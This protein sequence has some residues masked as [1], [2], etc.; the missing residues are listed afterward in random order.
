MPKRYDRHTAAQLE[1]NGGN[2]GQ[3]YCRSFA[4]KKIHSYILILKN[5]LNSNH[6][7]KMEDTMNMKS[8]SHELCPQVIMME[9]PA[10]VK[11]IT[12]ARA[13]IR[14]SCL[15]ERVKASS[16]LSWIS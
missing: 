6:T 14:P 1:A 15:K 2:T 13:M 3:Y 8:G 11:P 7:A 16:L 10:S 4:P 12:Q 5:N 9:E